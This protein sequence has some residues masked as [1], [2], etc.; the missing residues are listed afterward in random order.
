MQTQQEIELPVI[1]DAEPFIQTLNHIDRLFDEI[2]P[3]LE[4]QT[5]EQVCITMEM[6]I[7]VGLGAR[8]SDSLLSK[9][10]SGITEVFAMNT[11]FSAQQRW[12]Q[13]ERD[14]FARSMGH[15]TDKKDLVA[16]IDAMEARLAQFRK[17]MYICLSAQLKL[18]LMVRD[19]GVGKSGH[20]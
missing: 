14:F 12:L 17:S 18:E 3:K 15:E 10:E 1:T 9:L 13:D 6:E 19:T 8:G 2:E 16:R 7:L 5:R 11:R 4:A 20:V